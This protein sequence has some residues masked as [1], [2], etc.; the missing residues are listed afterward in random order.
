[1][2][3]SYDGQGGLTA[4]GSA[5]QFWLER[6]LQNEETEVLRSQDV[7]CLIAALAEG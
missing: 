5:Q 2:S 4:V 3:M 1:M 7:L 6:L